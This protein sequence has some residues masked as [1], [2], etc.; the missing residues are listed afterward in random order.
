V[1]FIVC[2]K[3]VGGVWFMKE[4]TG[5][6]SRGFVWGVF[7]SIPLWVSAIGWA[8]IVYSWFC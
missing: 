3:P 5:G 4:E 6:F 8:R 1:F 2:K 7:L